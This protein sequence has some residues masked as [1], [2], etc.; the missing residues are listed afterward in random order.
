MSPRPL[1][2]LRQCAP[3]RTLLNWGVPVSRNANL[4]RTDRIYPRLSR[5]RLAA[6]LRPM[7]R[8]GR[9]ACVVLP[10]RSRSPGSRPPPGRGVR[11]RRTGSARRPARRG[12]ADRRGWLAGGGLARAT[13]RDRAPRA[14][15]STSDIGRTTDRPS[16]ASR[17]RGRQ[18]AC[19]P[20]SS[21]AETDRITDEFGTPSPSYQAHELKEAT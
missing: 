3:R 8:G 11:A 19:R 15:R 18:A 2:L 7:L 5:A 9:L 13:C 16:V 1:H 21:R 14:D 17:T 10:P 12:S 20:P 6:V 4:R